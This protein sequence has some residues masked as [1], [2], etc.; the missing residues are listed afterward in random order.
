MLIAFAGLPGSGKSSL[1][2]LLARRLQ[3]TYLRIDTIEQ[4]LRSWGSLTAEITAEG[5]VIAYNLA[6]ENLL[7]GQTVIADSVNPI[8]TTRQAWLDIAADAKVA[9]VQVEV[10][11]SDPVE[12]RRRIETRTTD[13]ADFRL[14]SWDAV[15]T[16]EYQAWRQPRIVIDTA[17]KD[18]TA[19]LEELMSKLPTID[20]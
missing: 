5:Y 11:C 10:V 8:E 6:R 19:S 9:A 1:A 14:P 3:A 12:H 20:A 15:V 17:G 16:H 7:V 13:I 2:K 4:A 18:L